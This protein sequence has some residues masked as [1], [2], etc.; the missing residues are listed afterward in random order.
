MTNYFFGMSIFKV[1]ST[2]CLRGGFVLGKMLITQ[3][4]PIWF[5]VTSIFVTENP[6]ANKRNNTVM[7]EYFLC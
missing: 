4:K 7:I 6:L 5:I 2:M 3:K 1:G